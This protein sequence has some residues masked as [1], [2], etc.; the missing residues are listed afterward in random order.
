MGRTRI[1]VPRRMSI[2]PMASGSVKEV[3]VGTRSGSVA[4]VDLFLS[5]Y[6]PH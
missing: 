2:I 3:K 5:N 6:I 1:A 4:G